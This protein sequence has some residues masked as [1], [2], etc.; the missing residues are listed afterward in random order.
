MSKLDKLREIVKKLRS[1]EG[2]DWDKEQTHESL[3]PYLLEE[4][5]EVIEAIEN[6]D[7][8]LLKEELGDLLL[9]VIFQADLAENDNKFNIEDS[10]DTINHKLISR[11][12]HIF[13]NK[14]DDS[15]GKG[16]WELQKQKEKK[17]DSVLDGVPASLPALL[18]S[19]RIQEKASSVGFDWNN[20]DRVI[21]KVDEEVAE[22]KEAIANNNGIEEELGDVL[23]TIVN[24]SRHLEINPDQ[25][26][27]NSINKFINRFKLIE[28]DLKLKKI[29]MKN[30]TLDELDK[31]WEKN[32]KNSV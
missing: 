32:K 28:K 1:P 8:D 29:D 13:K 22:L 26:L 10:I 21:E 12:P 19:R 3:T 18:K 30:M 24:L 11:H 23:F 5:Y 7:Y 14:N 9:H 25:A 20:T 6:K 31:I 4:V 27:R 15:W 17:R 2:C 16:N